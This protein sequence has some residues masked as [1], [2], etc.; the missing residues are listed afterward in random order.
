MLVIYIHSLGHVSY[1]ATQVLENVSLKNHFA[2]VQKLVQNNFHSIFYGLLL[3]F[4]FLFVFA[5]VSNSFYIETL[6]FTKHR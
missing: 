3:V 6:V 1:L 2:M 5:F 4:V